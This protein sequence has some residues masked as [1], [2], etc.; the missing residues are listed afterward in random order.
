MI[1]L[2]A[3]TFL[4]TTSLLAST[5]SAQES[6]PPAGAVGES[7]AIIVTGS[8]LPSTDLTAAAPV[9]VLDRE[10]I[11]QTGAQSVGEL[12]RELPV[13]SPSASESAGR[14]NNGSANVALRGL[15]AVNTLVLI[16]GR[17]SR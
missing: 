14:G 16:D 5:A 12:L 10:E 4:V 7:E 1:R 13:A 9:T 15:S 6:E 11:D 3:A 8:R 2:K 17:C